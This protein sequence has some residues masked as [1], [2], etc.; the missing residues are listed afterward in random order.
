MNNIE[1]PNYIPLHMSFRIVT[2]IQNNAYKVISLP[3][4]LLRFYKGR[5]LFFFFLNVCFLTRG[6][7]NCS[8]ARIYVLLKHLQYTFLYKRIMNLYSAVFI[9]F[10]FL[11][12]IT[13]MLRK[14]LCLIVAFAKLR[15]FLKL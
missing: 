14:L 4:F 12:M 3:P 7:D 8:F 11:L 6:Q 5:G 9:C 15:S 2:S 1:K 10:F 13:K